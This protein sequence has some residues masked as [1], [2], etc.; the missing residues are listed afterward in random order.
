M[1]E[2]SEWNCHSLMFSLQLTDPG[3]PGRTGDHVTVIHSNKRVYLPVVPSSA[4]S[5]LGHLVAPKGKP[6]LRIRI[7]FAQ[8]SVLWLHWQN[9]LDFR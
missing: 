3:A 5:V 1:Y 7:V 9:D 4:A 6:E 8:V 2:P